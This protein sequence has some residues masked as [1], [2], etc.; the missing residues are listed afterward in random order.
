MAFAETY[1]RNTGKSNMNS[2]K[3]NPMLINTPQ[4]SGN[5]ESKENLTSDDMAAAA[6]MSRMKVIKR[7]GA[8]T[9]PYFLCRGFSVSELF[10]SSFVQVT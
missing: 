6:N 8:I 10:T 1:F 5:S 7:F 9:D 2:A 4:I 3:N